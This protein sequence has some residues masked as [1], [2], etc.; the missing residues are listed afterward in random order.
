VSKFLVIMKRE[1]A[2]VVKK[3]SFIV[4]TL[5]T[6]VI[7][8]ALMFVPSL[9]IRSGG[10]AETETYAIIDRDGQQLGWKVAEGME[11]YTLDDEGT[12]AFVLDRIETFTAGDNQRYQ[13]V[14]DSLVQDIRD[15]RLDHLLVLMP[16]AHTADSN[17]LLI[18]NSDDS[19]TVRRFEYQLSQV[20]SQRRIEQSGISVP[21]DSVMALT[22]G[23]S[24]PKQDTKG[25]SINPVFKLLIG[26]VLVMLIYMLILI[27]GQALMRSVIEEKATR[28]VEVLISSASPFQLMAGKIIGTGLAALT[29]VGIWIVAGAGLMTYSTTSGTELPGFVS[30]VVLN[31]ATV[32]SFACFLLLG[33]LMYSTIFA[34]IGSIVN[35]DKEAQPLM[36]PVIFVLFMPAM[37]VSPA[38]IENPDVGWIRVMSLI[39]TYTPLIMMMRVAIG[40]PMIEGNSLFSPLM[41]EAGLGMV[42]IVLFTIALVWVT[43]RVFRIG[44]LMYGKRPTLPEIVRWVRYK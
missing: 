39:P 19:R 30:R 36:L 8:A 32:V 34:L 6:P 28:I 7:M 11:E 20:L 23:V 2:Q 16:K 21:V 37:L 15:R 31:P 4:M 25:E 43:A 1:Y 22:K 42:G 10:L 9:L 26:M 33:Y 5:L 35:S 13:L 18:T 24:L 17:L 41:A 44:I 3:K 14:Y 38:I 27:D 29:Q 12:P 40:A